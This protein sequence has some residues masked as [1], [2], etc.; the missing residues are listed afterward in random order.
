MFGGIGIPELMVILVIALVI[1]GPSKLPNMGKSL[2]QAI[3][4]FRKAMS[5]RD[6]PKDAENP[7]K[8]KEESRS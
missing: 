6:P 8:T 7:G 4:G 2:G 1:F 3:R 5:E